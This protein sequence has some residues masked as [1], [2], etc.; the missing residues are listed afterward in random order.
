MHIPEKIQMRFSEF[1]KKP[2]EHVLYW[3]SIWCILILGCVY[4]AMLLFVY[5]T[6]CY[7]FM[8]CK[9]K[10]ILG[11]PCP[12]CGGTR[13]IWYL[14]HGN[15]I[16][17]LYYHAFAVYGAVWYAMFFVT[18]TLQRITKGKLSGMPFC[19]KYLYFAVVILVA[20]YLLKLFVAGYAV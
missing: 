9:M 2:T 11:I 19:E 17:A 14:L 20:Q 15:V 13:A 16:K 10:R 18:Q 7:E 6:G 8:E 12:G 1:E 3:L 4:A 5:K